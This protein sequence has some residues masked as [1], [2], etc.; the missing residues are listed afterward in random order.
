MTL[1]LINLIFNLYIVACV[2]GSCTAILDT[3]IAAIKILHL[4]IIKC[5]IFS[6]VE[7]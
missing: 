3:K 5:D 7:H 1:V 2:E 4:H 6:V